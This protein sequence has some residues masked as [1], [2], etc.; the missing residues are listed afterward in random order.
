MCNVYLGDL[1]NTKHEPRIK[2][3]RESKNNKQ[4]IPKCDLIRKRLNTYAL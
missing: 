2:D 3:N 4:L 1:T